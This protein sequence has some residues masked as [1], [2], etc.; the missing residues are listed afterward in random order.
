[1]QHQSGTITFKR[2]R[3]TRFTR[4]VIELSSLTSAVRLSRQM[5]GPAQ[6][7]HFHW[8]L[9]RGLLQ[10]TF[11][12]CLHIESLSRVLQVGASVVYIRKPYTFVLSVR[13]TV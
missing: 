4:F 1:M 3:W 8:L 10:A 13:P 6:A 9:I 5:P 12:L 7:A 2:R 11:V